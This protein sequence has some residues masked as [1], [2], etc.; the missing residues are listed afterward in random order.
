MIRSRVHGRARSARAARRRFQDSPETGVE[1]YARKV[2]LIFDGDVAGTEAANRALDVCLAQRIDIKIASVPQ[3]KDPCDFILTAGRERFEQIVEQGV[4]VFQYKWDRLKEKFSGD[5]A[6]ATRRAAVEEYLQTI[7]TGFRAGNVAAL[8]CGLR[9]NQ[10]SSIIGLS[11]EQ[12]NAEI[13]KLIRRGQN[14]AN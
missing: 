4:D 10:I 1:R 7:A 3:G 11:S 9:V 8:D 12:I 6:L 5:D 2:V 13:N 14:A